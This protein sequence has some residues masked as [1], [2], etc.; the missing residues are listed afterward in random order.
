[1]GISLLLFF[2]FLSLSA[3]FSSSETAL[4]SLPKTTLHRWQYKGNFWQR[5]VVS[6]MAVNSAVLITILLSNTFVNV[7]LTILGEEVKNSL[8]SNYFIWADLLA[9]FFITIVLLFFG[10]IVPKSLALKNAEKVA[11]FYYLP[12]H[13]LFCL[14][15]PFSYFFEL[16]TG[17]WVKEEKSQEVSVEQLSTFVKIADEEK[18]FN[19]NEVT[20]LKN[21]FAL[22]ELL[23]A[24]CLTPRTK[25]ISVASTA[26][27]SNI[28]ATISKCRHSRLPVIDEDDKVYGVLVVKRFKTLPYKLQNKWLNLAVEKPHFIPEQAPL[29]KAAKNLSQKKI[30]MTIVVD[31]YG[32]L[33]GILTYQDIVERVVGEVPDEYKSIPNSFI[34]KKDNFWVLRGLVELRQVSQH[35]QIEFNYQGQA[36]T[37]NG[38]LIEFLERLPQKGDVVTLGNYQFKVEKTLD[39]HVIEVIM[40]QIE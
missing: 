39:S 40:N 8:F 34:E 29:N 24:N 3:Y 6:L 15:R 4:F 10:E 25:V 37:V 14:F 23:V 17:L 1:M 7:Y 9:P 20:I 33:E 35:C 18:I 31:E 16:A 12:L 26:T 30:P 11:P 2:I 32:S 38:Y 27:Y 19:H 21:I 36:R 22:R 13:I 28:S 5:K